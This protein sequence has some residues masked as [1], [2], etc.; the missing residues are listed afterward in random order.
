MFIL[1]YDTS[2]CKGHLWILV[3]AFSEWEAVEKLHSL[4][5]DVSS[6]RSVL[7]QW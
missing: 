7:K 3:C 1:N 6:V 2:Y 5:D 4:I